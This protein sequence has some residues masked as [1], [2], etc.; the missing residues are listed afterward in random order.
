MIQEGNLWAAWFG[1]VVLSV[2]FWF[3]K[4]G[5]YIV[6][7]ECGE[8]RA[9]KVWLV[10]WIGFGLTFTVSLGATLLIASIGSLYGLIHLVN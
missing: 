7:W 4:A 5:I 1:L 10:A 8:T 9:N 2:G 3:G 6:R